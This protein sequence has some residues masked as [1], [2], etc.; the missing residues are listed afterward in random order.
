MVRLLHWRDGVEMYLSA[1]E[2][3]NGERPT[4]S[5]SAPTLSSLLE[6][7]EAEDCAIL[8]TAIKI[9]CRR[10]KDGRRDDSEDVNC[11]TLEICLARTLI[12]LI[13]GIFSRFCTWTK[14]R[15]FIHNRLE[16]TRTLVLNRA[17]ISTARGID[18]S[19]REAWIWMWIVTA[20]TW[21]GETKATAK[22]PDKGVGMM[23]ELLRMDK[24]L[25]NWETTCCIAEL[26]FSN[27]IV[28]VRWKACWQNAVF[29]VTRD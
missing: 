21:T 26:F 3:S 11:I 6:H 16:L 25:Q 15:N 27:R 10:Q 19:I 22:S 5:S 12:L 9:L 29:A 14:T 7:T 23:M 13:T 24:S 1:G 20:Q 28:A 18:D 17:L 2:Q 4:D 8:Y